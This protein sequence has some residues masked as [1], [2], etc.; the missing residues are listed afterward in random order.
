MSEQNARKV[1]AEKESFA[2]W[3]RGYARTCGYVVRGRMVMRPRLSLMPPLWEKELEYLKK[4]R[5]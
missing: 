3:V 5:S 1:V 2:A 4:E